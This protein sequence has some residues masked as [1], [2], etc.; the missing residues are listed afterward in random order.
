MFVTHF[1]TVVEYESDGTKV[2]EFGSTLNAS[3]RG[4]AVNDATD[5]VFVGDSSNSK[6]RVFGT[7]AVVPDLT[8]S[9]ATN[10]KRQEFDANGAVDLAGGPQA[11]ECKVEWAK[12]EQFGTGYVPYTTENS[13]NCSNSL[14]ITS[15]EAL[16]AHVIGLTSQT[17]YQYRFKVA[18]ENGF[19]F[20]ANKQFRTTDAVTNVQTLTPQT[21]GWKAGP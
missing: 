3:L 4:I 1:N 13:S 19:N 11:T 21:R 16:T 18:N 20:S 6:V 2:G 8:N 14:P 7:P 10:V 17:N 5:E 9:E 12:Q 15:N